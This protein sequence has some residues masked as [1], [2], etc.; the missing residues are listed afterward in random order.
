MKGNP[1][2]S[3]PSGE[4]EEGEEEG[5]DDD[6]ELGGFAA[7]AGVQVPPDGRGAGDALPVSEVRGP[8]HRRAD[9]R[10]HRYL[11]VRP[12]GAPR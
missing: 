6:D 7:A 12:L 11:Q 10:R 9:H 1:P 8:S 4:E 5:E 3:S 2:S